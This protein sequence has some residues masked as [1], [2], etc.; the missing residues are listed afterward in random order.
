MSNKLNVNIRHSFLEVGHT[1]NKGDSVHATI[2]NQAKKEEKIFT[3]DK[4]CTVIKNAKKMLHITR[5]LK[6]IMVL[7]RITKNYHQK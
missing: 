5:L 1:Q 4:W 3:E 7:F 6:L 2:E